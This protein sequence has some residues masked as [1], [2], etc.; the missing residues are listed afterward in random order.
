MENDLNEIDTLFMDLRIK[1]KKAQT[2]CDPVDYIQRH[3]DLV[4]ALS[5]FIIEYFTRLNAEESLVPSD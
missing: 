1:Y 5:D 4:Y 3:R 2:V